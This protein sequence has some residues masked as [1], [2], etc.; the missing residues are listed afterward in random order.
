MYDFKK[1][2]K[3]KNYM[4]RKLID[5]KDISFE[6]FFWSWDESDVER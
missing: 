6:F 4:F 5:F 2:K 3:G 1:L